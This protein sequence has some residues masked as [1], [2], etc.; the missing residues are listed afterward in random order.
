MSLPHLRRWE[1]GLLLG[2]VT[3][4]HE[5][6]TLCFPSTPTTRGTGT[7]RWHRVQH[8]TPCTASWPLVDVLRQ[9]PSSGARCVAGLGAGLHGHEL[10]PLPS[11]SSPHSQNPL[12]R[13]DE[14][15]GER[16]HQEMLRGTRQEASGSPRRQGRMLRHCFPGGSADLGA[17][18][19]LLAP[20]RR[21]DRGLV[22]RG[23]AEGLRA[24]RC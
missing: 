5:R 21:Q 6:T 20:V 24:L 17:V 3:V 10:P 14:G 22:H 15:R 18:G 1:I 19:T 11:L 4:Q 16:S 7:W 8:R 12:C 9:S 2:S 23:A 13:P